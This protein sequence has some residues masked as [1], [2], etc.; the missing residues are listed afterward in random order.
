MALSDE[1]GITAQPF[2]TILRVNRQSDLRRIRQICRD[3]AIARII[4]GHPLHMSGAAGE[5]AAE[6]AR[7]AARLKKATRIETELVDERLTS[8]QAEQTLTET[9][10]SRRRNRRAIDDIAATIL[11]REYLERTSGDAKNSKTEND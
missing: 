4:V 8:W 9:S 5:M 3:H 1:L 10:S 2:A 6:A 11:L 7:F